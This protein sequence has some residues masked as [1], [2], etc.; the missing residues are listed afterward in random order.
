[1]HCPIAKETIQR[2]LIRAVNWV[3]DAVMTLPAL[4]A[5][6]ENFPNSEITVLAKPWVA[7][8]YE[9]H[10]AVDAVLPF[11]KGEGAFSGPG[12][13]LR[14]MRRI[15]RGRYD[16]AILFQNAFLAAL[17]AK[18]GGVPCRLGYRTDGRDLLLTHGIPREKGVLRLHQV[19]YYLSLL[20]A[21]GWK[22]PSRDPRLVVSPEKRTR[23]LDFLLKEGI[24]ETDFLVGLS[25]GAM[26]GSAKRWPPERFARIGDHV[27]SRWGGRVLILGSGKERPICRRVAESMHQP[28]RDVSGRT[29]LDAAV[30]LIQRCRLFVTNDSGL[31]HIAAALGV[32]TLAIFGPTDPTATGPRGPRTAIARRPAPCAPCLR[33][34][35]PTDHRCMTRVQVADVWAE[36]ERLRG[37]YP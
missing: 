29:G 17:L 15:R 22:A 31:M 13:M 2:I 12:E 4:E 6:R 11:Q 21:A 19:E 25:P 36:M 34:E 24:K 10:P 23:A 27:V 14:I 37:A 9:A 30:A 28:A 8:L 35:C 5:V 33:Q 18:L 3:G 20:R 26:F 1:M 32:P 16:L 7:S